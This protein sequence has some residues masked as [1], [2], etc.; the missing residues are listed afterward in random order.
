[1][2]WIIVACRMDK[3]YVPP[4]FLLFYRELAHYI[5][6]ACSSRNWLIANNDALELY[7][8]TQAKVAVK[9]IFGCCLFSLT[10]TSVKSIG[11]TVQEIFPCLVQNVGEFSLPFASVS[12]IL[13]KPT[14]LQLDV[15]FPAFHEIKLS[16]ARLIYLFNI[17]LERN[18][19]T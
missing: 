5:T 3:L 1:M 4:L 11:K 2:I 17:Q 6:H 13:N 8:G 14:P 19:G 10:L 12:N 9:V 16:F 15:Y 18:V 7:Q